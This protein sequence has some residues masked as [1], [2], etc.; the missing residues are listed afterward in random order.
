MQPESTPDN[1]LAAAMALVR[2]NDAIRTTVTAEPLRT[3]SEWLAD[4][5][6]LAPPKLLVPF[7]VL[8]S[9]VTL[10]AA[11]EKTGKSTLLGQA[12]AA[13]S[14]G[15]EFLGQSCGPARVVWYAIDEAAP[16]A[17][18]RLAGCGAEGDAVVIQSQRP[19]PEHMREHIATFRPSLV[20]VDTLTELLTGSL[21]NDRDAMEWARALGPYMQVFR[22]TD[23]AAVLVH[24]STKDGRDYRGS[25]QLGAKVDVI[26]MLRIPGA[27]TDAEDDPDADPELE[28]RRVLEVK[29]RGL[30]GRDRLH[31]DGVAYQLG[32]GEQG[33]A[34]RIIRAVSEGHTTGNSVVTAVQGRRQTIIATIDR[35]VEQGKL[36]RDGARLRVPLHGGGAGGGSAAV[37]AHASGTTSGTTVKHVEHRSADTREPLGNHSEPPQRGA[38]TAWQPAQLEVVPDFGSHTPRNGNHS[39]DD[40]H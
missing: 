2:Q 12:V 15:G 34:P 21:Q 36:M 38:G 11:R 32:E 33:I 24:H 26:A 22:D 18:R 9:R 25:G 13:L 8:E 1:V 17:V 30:F 31:F 16:D 7:L 10:L 5:E 20:V 40:H 29:G 19:T 37:F 35:L 3:L 28:A 27:G 39:R 23:T 6:A 14:R 4:P